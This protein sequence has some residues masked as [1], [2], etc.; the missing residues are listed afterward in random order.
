MGCAPSARESPN[1]DRATRQNAAGFDFMPGLRVRRIGGCGWSGKKLKN[2]AGVSGNGIGFVW[3]DRVG[4][5]GDS[6]EDEVVEGALIHKVK[7]SLVTVHQGDGG[8]GYRTGE[9]FADLVQLGAG[10]VGAVE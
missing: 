9:G 6:H 3:Y 4:R 1:P 5:V 7:A 10:G 2:F 8:R